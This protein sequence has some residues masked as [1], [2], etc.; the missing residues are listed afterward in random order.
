MPGGIP[1]SGG[2]KKSKGKKALSSS[3]VVKG[4]AK[5]KVAPISLDRSASKALEPSLHSRGF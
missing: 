4:R 3:K 5:K 2:A 1:G